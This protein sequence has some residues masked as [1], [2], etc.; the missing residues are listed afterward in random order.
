MKKSLLRKYAKLAVRSGVNVQK[1]QILVINAEANAYEFVR[2][3]TEEA[4][5][6]KAKKVVVNFSDEEVTHQTY[7]HC[8]KETL[9]EFPDYIYQQR[10]YYQDQGCCFLSIISS[11]PGLMSDVDVEKVAA[12]R[13][14]ASKKMEPL[15]KYTMNN[16]GQW[17]IVSLPTVA[18]AKMV[19]PQLSD[20]KALEALWKAVLDAVMVNDSTNPVK[21]WKDHS[22]KLKRYCDILNDYHFDKLHFTNSLGTDLYV[23]LV[24]KHIWVGGSSISKKKVEFNPNMPTEE[25]FC[26][27]QLDGVNGVVYASK[28][29][30]F[31]GKLIKDFS[32]TFKDGK[33]IEH[34]AKVNQDLLTTLLD[35]DE[36][37]RRLGEVALISYNSPISLSNILFYETLFDENASCHLALGDSYPENMEGGLM[38]DE[39]QLKANG[40]NSSSIHV[41]FMFGSEDMEVVGIKPDG[42]EVAIFHNGNFVF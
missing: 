41:D 35:S 39:E 33:V 4:Y 23:Q 19:F 2:L 9:S 25:V 1:G 7:L 30:N 13:K 42:S 24:K 27:P 18:W 6:A 17:C 11:T 14:V 22:A 32:L 37:S 34:H 38:M 40:A 36:G 10:K 3:C 28:P 20:K 15:R 26:M 31:S 8:S 21:V 12:Y 5:K 29:L 16:I